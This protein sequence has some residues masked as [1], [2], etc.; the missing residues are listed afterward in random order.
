MSLQQER[1]ATLC[2]GLKL[3]RLSAEWPA[4]AQEAAAD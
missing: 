4:L 2:S 1:I 3:D